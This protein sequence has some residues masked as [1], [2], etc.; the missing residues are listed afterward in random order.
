MTISRYLLV[1][2]F[3]QHNN[4]V[5]REAAS[6]LI[7]QLQSYQCTHINLDFS[8]ITYISR[9]FA[10]QFHKEKLKTWNTKN[11]EIV[12]VNAEEDVLN[13]LF[14][15]AKTQEASSRAASSFSRLDLETRR[16]LKTYL[17]SL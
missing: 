12:V 5:T 16:S 10:D 8:G 6:E 1:T 4:L 9:S 15:V 13:M 11:L 2:Q 17:Y 7:N 14:T 3:I